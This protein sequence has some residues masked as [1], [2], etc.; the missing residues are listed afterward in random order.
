MANWGRENIGPALAPVRMEFLS[1]SS[2]SLWP[3]NLRNRVVLRR[4]IASHTTSSSMTRQKKAV[5]VRD[6]VEWLVDDSAI[7]IYKYIDDL[8][9]DS[10]L[11]SQPMTVQASVFEASSWATR[12]GAVPI[13]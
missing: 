12:G 5:R 1:V 2:W 10:Y 4:G 13:K 3:A 6:E 11:K 9:T 7:R 8:L